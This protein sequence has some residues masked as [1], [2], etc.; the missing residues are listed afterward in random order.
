[1]IK[2][3]Q[4]TEDRKVIQEKSKEKFHSSFKAWIRVVAFIVAAV[5]LPE[6]AAQAVEYDWRVLWSKPAIGLPSGSIIAPNYLQNVQNVNI[7]QAVKRILKDIANKPVT[8]IKISDNLTINLD[9]PLKMSNQRIDELYNWLLGKPCG[10]KAL[11]DF[12]SYK[13]VKVEEQDI[14]V[15]VLSVDIL[16]D[17]IKPEGNPK[18]IKNSLYALSQA[19]IFFGQ[20]LYPVKI[21][22]ALESNTRGLE[23][24]AP[25]IAHLNGDHYVLVT[26]VT[27]DKVYFSDNHRE[28]FLPKDKFLNGFSGYCLVSFLPDGLQALPVSESKKI[29]G[30]TTPSVWNKHASAAEIQYIREKTLNSLKSEV[31][32]LRNKAEAA[33]V[34]DLAIS[35]GVSLAMAGFSSVASSW[36]STGTYAGMPSYAR[37]ALTG[38][39]TGIVV[40]SL[41]TGKW[42]GD[43]WYL[44]AAGGALAGLGANY[45]ASSWND[46]T[47]IIFSYAQ[48]I[49]EYS[50]YVSSPVKGW[51]SSQTYAGMNS[52]V[53]YALTGAAAGVAVNRLKTGD[54]FGDNW[55]FY[56]AGGTAA[57]LAV[58]AWNQY[59]ASSLTSPATA[60]VA[61]LSVK[62]PG[63]FS[64]VGNVF[65]GM[66]NG[67]IAYLSSGALTLTGVNQRE[68]E[69]YASFASGALLGMVGGLGKLTNGLQ[70]HWVQ[71]GI[72]GALTNAAGTYATRLASDL[73][74][75]SNV[76][77]MY[78]GNTAGLAVNTAVN[79]ALYNYNGQ[80]VDTA[81]GKIYATNLNN[82][83]LTEAGILS[84]GSATWDLTKGRLISGLIGSGAAEIITRNPG[85]I[86]LNSKD[87]D[88]LP[89]V[90]AISSGIGG[91]AG[92]YFDKTPVYQSI[93]RGLLSGFL[94]IGAAKVES[95]ILK[96]NPNMT[97]VMAAYLT[98][99]GTAA[100]RGLAESLLSPLT[101]DIQSLNSTKAPSAFIPETG[102]LSSVTDALYRDSLNALSF[103]YSGREQSALGEISYMR[104]LTSTFAPQTQE[105]LRQQMSS[106]SFYGITTGNGSTV[107]LALKDGTITTLILISDSSDAKIF[108]S[109]NV[110]S[111]LKYMDAAGNIW[112]SNGNGTF[113]LY[114]AK[115]S[116][117]SS[118][119]AGWS[120]LAHDIY[121]SGAIRNTEGIIGV[122]SS[123]R[124]VFGLPLSFMTTYRDADSVLQSGR[125]TLYSNTDKLSATRFD[126]LSIED[127]WGNLVFNQTNQIQTVIDKNGPAKALSVIT[128]NYWANGSGYTSWKENLYQDNGE[129]KSNREIEIKENKLF[130][131]NITQSVQPGVAI[132]SSFVNAGLQAPASPLINALDGVF[133]SST[134]RDILGVATLGAAGFSARTYKALGIT[135]DILRSSD[136]D[137]SFARLAKW[138]IR[139]LGSS[140]YGLSIVPGAEGLNYGWTMTGALTN[141]IWHKDPTPQQL[142]EWKEIKNQIRMAAASLSA[143]D[144]Q[145]D[146]QEAYR[147]VVTSDKWKNKL[148]DLGLASVSLDVYASGKPVPGEEIFLQD[149]L[150]IVA[151][152][153]QKIVV[154]ANGGNIEGALVTN[155]ASHKDIMGNFQPLW[156]RWSGQWM[157]DGAY[158][159]NTHI[160]KDTA[161]AMFKSLGLQKEAEQVAAGKLDTAFGFGVAR[162]NQVFEVASGN[163]Y[164]V[165][166]SG[167]RLNA[168]MWQSQG[169][170][171]NAL[172]PRG[173]SIWN[174]ITDPSAIRVEGLSG[175]AVLKKEANNILVSGA[176]VSGEAPGGFAWD[177]ETGRTT[178]KL[179]NGQLLPTSSFTLTSTTKDGKPARGEGYDGVKRLFALAPSDYLVPGAGGSDKTDISSLKPGL[180][181]L[182]W[183]IAKE[184]NL[185]AI[186]PENGKVNMMNGALRPIAND[187]Y[188]NRGDMVGALAQTDRGPMPVKFSYGIK[189]RIS[190]GADGMWRSETKPQKAYISGT[191]GQKVEIT[192]SIARNQN[193]LKAIVYHE[194]PV[195]AML[196]SER[197]TDGIVNLFLGAKGATLITNNGVNVPLSKAE[198]AKYLYNGKPLVLTK[199]ALTFIDAAA[200]AVPEGKSTNAATAVRGQAAIINLES[201]TESGAAIG[202]GFIEFTA[203]GVPWGIAPSGTVG[204]AVLDGTIVTGAT[205]A[206]VTAAGYLFE[207]LQGV[208][209]QHG[210]LDLDPKNWAWPLRG[211]SGSDYS[212]MI[213]L[214][215]KDYQIFS[216][217]GSEKA[218]LLTGEFSARIGQRINY[219]NGSI[220]VEFLGKGNGEFSSVLA[221]NKPHY[222][223]TV[224]S[225]KKSL[226]AGIQ[227]IWAQGAHWGIE[228]SVD[229]SKKQ[230]ILLVNNS[231]MPYIPG[232]SPDAVKGAKGS[233]IRFTRDSYRFY[234]RYFDKQYG[235]M[236]KGVLPFEIGSS[237]SDPRAFRAAPL[238]G[239]SGTTLIASSGMSIGRATIKG[240]QLISHMAPNGPD[241]KGTSAKMRVFY[242][243]QAAKPIV[244]DV[245]D[246]DYFGATFK[247]TSVVRPVGRVVNDSKFEIF[248]EIISQNSKIIGGI[249][250]NDSTGKP[251]KVPVTYVDKVLCFAVD[252]NVVVPSK[253]LPLLSPYMIPENTT[254]SSDSAASNIASRIIAFGLDLET[255]K[256]LDDSQ[257]PVNIQVDTK[258]QI[259]VAPLFG[260]LGTRLVLTG[261]GKVGEQAILNNPAGSRYVS[262]LE[263]IDGRAVQSWEGTSEGVQVQQSARE[264]IVNAPVSSNDNSGSGIILTAR[265]VN[266]PVLAFEPDSNGSAANP[267]GGSWK[268][269]SLKWDGLPAMSLKSSGSKEPLQLSIAKNADKTD[270]PG[271]WE[272][273]LSRDHA[274]DVPL[275]DLKGHLLSLDNSSNETV[276]GKRISS[277]RLFSFGATDPSARLNNKVR[278]DEGSLPVSINPDNMQSRLM[279]QDA[280]TQFTAVQGI[281]LGN[282]E[283][284]SGKYISTIDIKAGGASGR[285]E[286]THTFTGSLPGT[287]VKLASGE[288]QLMSD[289]Q[290]AKMELAS[291]GGPAGGLSI[292]DNV[293][294]SLKIIAGSFGQIG[295]WLTYASGEIANLAGAKNDSAYYLRQSKEFTAEGLAQLGYFDAKAGRYLEKGI[296]AGFATLFTGATAFGSGADYLLGYM[297]GIN[298]LKQWGNEAWTRTNLHAIRSIPGL[299]YSEPTRK[300]IYGYLEENGSIRVDRVGDNSQDWDLI[301]PGTGFKIKASEAGGLGSLKAGIEEGNY[302]INNGY[303]ASGL[304]ELAIAYLGKAGM[305]AIELG[306]LKNAGFSITNSSIQ[307]AAVSDVLANQ[308]S[309]MSSGKA[310]TFGQ[311]ALINFSFINPAVTQS[312]ALTVGIPN[313]VSAGRSVYDNRSK[314]NSVANF[315]ESVWNGFLPRDANFAL[316]AAGLTGPLGKSIAAGEGYALA[317][318]VFSQSALWGQ[319]NAITGASLA[320]LNGDGQRITAS[321]V[322]TSY[323][324][325]AANGA[326]FG[327]IFGASSAIVNLSSASAI[328]NMI[329]EYPLI[330]SIAI[331]AGAFPLA[332][333]IIE[334]ESSDQDFLSRLA[335]NS[336]LLNYARGAVIGLG[337]WYGL[338]TGMITGSGLDRFGYGFAVGATA[339]AGVNLTGDLITGNTKPLRAYIMDAVSG[340]FLGGLTALYIGKQGMEIT[341]NL[342]TFG[343]AG[344]LQETKV[345]GILNLSKAVGPELLYNR[346]LAGAIEWTA[347]SPAF[348][349]GGA[350]WN[351]VFYKAGLLDVHSDSA[352][353]WLMVER[354]LGKDKNGSFKPVYGPLTMTDILQSAV[355]GPRSGLWMKPMIEVFQMKTS[356]AP[357]LTSGGLFEKI[358]NIGR[359]GLEKSGLQKNAADGIVFKAINPTAGALGRA[360]S[361]GKWIDSSVIWMPGF[362]SGVDK[363]VALADSVLANAAGIQLDA[364]P[365]KDLQTGKQGSVNINGKEIPLFSVNGYLSGGE[366]EA[367]KWLP[368]FMAPSLEPSLIDRAGAT[369]LSREDFYAFKGILRENG[370]NFEQAVAKMTGFSSAVKDNFIKFAH[371]NLGEPEGVTRAVLEGQA[372]FIWDKG[373]NF[374]KAFDAVLKGNQEG[375]IGYLN[376]FVAQ[377][378]SYP[379]EGIKTE[380]LADNGPQVQTE[381]NKIK[382][383]SSN[384]GNYVLVRKVVDASI[385]NFRSGTGL[386]DFATSDEAARVS[387]AAIGDTTDIAFRFPGRKDIILKLG[388]DRAIKTKALDSLFESARK[389]GSLI[390]GI[391]LGEIWRD[392][393][394]DNLKKRFET[395]LTANLSAITDK[396]VKREYVSSVMSEVES[397]AYQR[398]QGKEPAITGKYKDYFHARER[399]ISA[400]LEGAD[401]S[402]IHQLQLSELGL[403]KKGLVDAYNAQDK[404]TAFGKIKDFYPD[405]KGS[406]KALEST[407]GLIG[408]YVRAAKITTPITDLDGFVKL[409][410]NAILKELVDNVSAAEY[411]R[412]IK[413]F[414]N[415]S[416]ALE[417]LRALRNILNAGI[418]ADTLNT[419]AG[420]VN[421]L[422]GELSTVCSNKDY[423]RLSA[424]KENTASLIEIAGGLLYGRLEGENTVELKARNRLGRFIDSIQAREGSLFSKALEKIKDSPL[425]NEKITFSV[426]QL[427]EYSSEIGRF[428]SM[429]DMEKA[430]SGFNIGALTLTQ[431]LKVGIK[432]GASLDDVIKLQPIVDSINAYLGK[433]IFQ[434]GSL[435]IAGLRPDAFIAQNIK[436]NKEGRNNESEIYGIVIASALKYMEG[437]F[438]KG[439]SRDTAEGQLRMI[440]GLSKG[441]S[442]QQSSG[443]G[444]TFAF[445]VEMALLAA[446]K[447]EGI[448]GKLVYKNNEVL[449]IKNSDEMGQALSSGVKANEL[450]NAEFLG[451]FGLEIKNGDALDNETDSGKLKD[452][453][454]DAKMITV[455]S[456][457]KFGHLRNRTDD[458]DLMRAIYNHDVVRFDEFH[459]PFSDKTTFISSY[460]AEKLVDKSPA[461][462][463]RAEEVF[464]IIEPLFENGTISRETGIEEARANK[465]ASFYEQNGVTVI[466]RQALDILKDRGIGKEEVGAYLAARDAQSQGNFTV[467]GNK[468]VPSNR[469]EAQAKKVF[470]E[471][472]FLAAIYARVAAQKEKLGYSGKDISLIK[473]NL[474]ISKSSS[475]ATLSEMLRFKKNA[476]IAGASGTME[477]VRSML[478]FN[479]GNRVLTA[480]ESKGLETAEIMPLNAKDINLAVTKGLIVFVKDRDA[481]A[482]IKANL[483][484]KGLTVTEI[485]EGTSAGDILDISKR[486][487]E[488]RLI[489]LSNERGAT[490]IDYKGAFDLI[491]ADAHNWT[492]S[493]LIQA[494]NRNNRSLREDIEEGKRLVYY[495]DGKLSV[496]N[497]D[498][499]TMKKIEEIGA[500]GKFIPQ[501]VGE[502]DGDYYRRKVEY[503][504]KAKEALETS[505]ALVFQVREA[506]MS[507]G[508]I[509]KLKTMV[510]Q[511]NTLGDTGLSSRL[512]E[513][514]K[515]AIEHKESY[516]V[517]ISETGQAPE[518]R[519]RM[520]LEEVALK[521]EDIF[522]KVVNEP[523]A[524]DFLRS[525]ARSVLAEAA[526]ILDKYDSIAY[527]DKASFQDASGLLGVA[528]VAKSPE[529][530]QKSV[531]PDEIRNSNFDSSHPV[532]QIIE[533]ARFNTAD[534]PRGQTGEL[535]L[536]ARQKI[537][538]QLE[539]ARLANGVRGSPD[540][541]INTILP[542]TPQSSPFYQVLEGFRNQ[543]NAIQA[544]NVNYFDYLQNMVEQINAY[545]YPTDENS[546]GYNFIPTFEK[547]S[548][549]RFKLADALV[550]LVDPNYTYDSLAS[551]AGAYRLLTPGAQQAALFY[552]SGKEAL[553]RAY[554]RNPAYFVK[555]LL[556]GSGSQMFYLYNS[557]INRENAFGRRA[558]ADYQKA[559]AAFT[560]EITSLSKIANQN[561]S[562][563]A[564]SKLRGLLEKSPDIFNNTGTDLL[565]FYAIFSSYRLFTQDILAQDKALR[566]YLTELT[567]KRDLSSAE[568]DILSF[569]GA[570]S[571]LSNFTDMF[572]K[573]ATTLADFAGINS[574]YSAELKK[575]LEKN[576]SM[577]KYAKRI[578]SIGEYFPSGDSLAAGGLPDGL[579]E[580]FETFTDNMQDQL[581]YS[582]PA[583]GMLRTYLYDRYYRSYKMMQKAIL[584]VGK[585]EVNVIPVITGEKGALLIDNT[586]STVTISSLFSQGQDYL[587]ADMNSAR[588]IAAYRNLRKVAAQEG[589]AGIFYTPYFRAEMLR[590]QALG[591]IALSGSLIAARDGKTKEIQEAALTGELGAGFIKQYL[592]KITSKLESYLNKLEQESVNKPQDEKEETAVKIAR[593]R[594]VI[595]NIGSAGNLQGVYGALGK[596]LQLIF[597]LDE[598]IEKAS[599]NTYEGDYGLADSTISEYGYNI[600]LNSRLL[601]DEQGGLRPGWRGDLLTV[602]IPHEITHTLLDAIGHIAGLSDLEIG[603][604]ANEEIVDSIVEKNELGSLMPFR[605]FEFGGGGAKT[606]LSSPAGQA[607]L[608]ELRL[609]KAQTL[610]AQ[611]PLEVFVHPALPGWEV[612]V[613][614]RAVFG[615]EAYSRPYGSWNFATQEGA[616]HFAGIKRAELSGEQTDKASSSLVT[617]LQAQ[618]PEGLSSSAPLAQKPVV[619]KASS[620]RQFEDIGGIKGEILRGIHMDYLRDSLSIGIENKG[621][622]IERLAGAG[623]PTSHIGIAN[624]QDA[625]NICFSLSESYDYLLPGGFAD[626]YNAYRHGARELTAG[627]D[628]FDGRVTLIISRAKVEGEGGVLNTEGRLI[629]V[630]NARE[631]GVLSP[632]VIIGIIVNRI[633]ADQVFEITRG[634]GKDRLPV[635]DI[636]GN[637]IK[638]EDVPQIHGTDAYKKWYATRKPVVEKEMAGSKSKKL[639]EVIR[640]AFNIK[641]Q[642]PNEIN[643]GFVG[644][645]KGIIGNI[646]TKFGKAEWGALKARLQKAGK[647]AGPVVSFIESLI[648]QSMKQQPSAS[649]QRPLSPTLKALTEYIEQGGWVAASSPLAQKQ[650]IIA[651]AVK[652]ALAVGGSGGGSIGKGVLGEGNGPGGSQREV[653]LP[654][655]EK[656][657]TALP[658][659]SPVT[660]PNTASSSTPVG[661][662]VGAISSSS[663][664]NPV[665]PAMLPGLNARLKVVSS[666]LSLITSNGKL[667]LAGLAPPAGSLTDS[668]S[669]LVSGFR[670]IRAQIS[671]VVAEAVSNL[672]NV[673]R[674]LAGSRSAISRDGEAGQGAEGA[675]G[676]T[677]NLAQGAGKDVGAAVRTYT[678]AKVIPGPETAKTSGAKSASSSITAKAGI[679]GSATSNPTIS[680][681]PAVGLKT[682]I[683]TFIQITAR[684]KMIELLSSGTKKFGMKDTP[685]NRK[686]FE[687]Y[688]TRK[689]GNKANIKEQTW[690]TAEE[691]VLR[692][693]QKKLEKQ[694]GQATVTDTAALEKSLKNITNGEITG[695]VAALLE[696]QAK[697]ETAKVETLE[698]QIAEAIDAVFARM[699]FEDIES[700]VVK[701]IDALV[702]L[703]IVFELQ[704]DFMQI[705]DPVFD[706]KGKPV[707]ESSNGNIVGPETQE[708]IAALQELKEAIREALREELAPI[709]N[710]VEEVEEIATTAEEKA[711]T[712]E[713]K[714]TTAQETSTTMQKIYETAIEPLVRTTVSKDA[715]CLPYALFT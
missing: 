542:Y 531:L 502:G 65:Q 579:Q 91:V 34:K 141:D 290:W 209:I 147:R 709:M 152:D 372:N 349:F 649:G 45:V 181:T 1:M 700:G 52:Y 378:N 711:T 107:S 220:A 13:G 693:I 667:H 442:V 268:T 102:F 300:S 707:Q 689:N 398:A 4:Q 391:E 224:M 304:Y 27:G 264:R 325:G 629:N 278:L 431:D 295:G 316:V 633:F 452:V 558:A 126:N 112:V 230:G 248:N 67:Q 469:G 136:S 361:F 327:A 436:S 196:D 2:Q 612:T 414:E 30:A 283:V 33:F 523:N 445:P 183:Q 356:K 160:T 708:I 345:L 710:K 157:L 348:T 573:E 485:K 247:I 96:N 477:S 308:I 540:A 644:K 492:S 625:A 615:G 591:L 171:V 228:A 139:P 399:R 239:V 628:N 624:Y 490:G 347:V 608:R 128:G 429:K 428:Y 217:S 617:S 377:R 324:Q 82:P 434:D 536:E 169:G 574:R 222:L 95:E 199:S 676:N 669:K 567:E 341:R 614:Q 277:D 618:K 60:P 666:P 254:G 18:V 423:A 161:A 89:Y 553:L 133:S 340:G 695:K 546:A 48:K 654:L 162:A 232:S 424:A 36:F 632:N 390:K 131:D 699:P 176:K 170:I 587:P 524:P 568:Q 200:L 249:L 520:A 313:A 444:K 586:P 659:S 552:E 319:V 56:A 550:A 235:I 640:E 322:L 108:M 257:V 87:L 684:E 309:Y 122:V 245:M 297:T 271:V 564:A 86:G 155:S 312:V 532:V 77:A 326:I 66:A 266:A 464:G 197:S 461:K 118:F 551:A 43:S 674:S 487:G 17:I 93:S 337:A 482:A 557:V 22:T 284:S 47:S 470:S 359:L 528:E 113:S 510:V 515:E 504:S 534:A 384:H 274:V 488:D 694:E 178:L 194:V 303:A 114:N 134:L 351:G 660:I 430:A 417:A 647:E 401:L 421:N 668:Y 119:I 635:F 132:G 364:R 516:K 562:V 499:R 613:E 507:R 565:G 223:K 150:S 35:V 301:D 214:A 451:Q 104:S 137:S 611:A 687:G 419:E 491:V 512:Q 149:G 192:G 110:R 46:P 241:F 432:E 547:F 173:H 447:A 373:N 418:T 40:N 338:K 581:D 508:I 53:R 273:A 270:I 205:R 31:S 585:A 456:M 468:I 346:A 263:A 54:W 425:A 237:D 100:I 600:N 7:P 381:I 188:Y 306:V 527:N 505:D 714:A 650:V 311:D 519:I 407:W 606:D 163:L 258:D 404:K 561:D 663:I 705:Y 25:F 130:F 692:D 497:L 259:S 483:E 10:S 72:S 189:E 21:D 697:Q 344:A 233:D 380:A 269:I 500:I 604:A 713:E 637:L 85:L 210:Q 256:F 334:S 240:D 143:N 664:V 23:S 39:V 696:A 427:S 560:R 571:S 80:Y 408:E 680:S 686:K 443:G 231:L 158:L 607:M 123:F 238:T 656:K 115:S 109:N 90:S 145:L 97:A 15:F 621:H 234:V 679:S 307:F 514:L 582:A 580:S 484:G 476:S 658:A 120:Q 246:S 583:Q 366:K 24:L 622:L 343:G 672:A 236:Y 704:L 603:N 509:E 406:S 609:S 589:G 498:T 566:D 285:G 9:K 462:I 153:G 402:R 365:L 630:S 433:I 165:I 124:E 195:G 673:L 563:T 549:N 70:D 598:E 81:A 463:S 691:R 449:V 58:N 276:S 616:D 503:S 172:G 315:G 400:Y 125:L 601:L 191:L 101:T 352:K 255:H 41:T 314:I 559:N 570:S 252:N 203:K 42:F 280:G 655:T 244:K 28:E 675:S 121:Q 670:Q 620:N 302:L 537:L 84:Y 272:A 555:G 420:A 103:G 538:G 682:W 639:L 657:E 460:G 597:R 69:L 662:L 521:A 440:V 99:A 437:K 438:G 219:N 426:E 19:A 554:L 335:S 652:A 275:A 175:S 288:Y 513:L 690:I 526:R 226:E 106:T 71:R 26:R 471:E 168:L 569:F 51:F 323:A 678:A 286:L 166:G 182:D 646:D 593:A 331:G 159:D 701:A 367:F 287:A 293:A 501:A 32:S 375:V 202:D 702:N 619:A 156:H 535:S 336:N 459:I 20:K 548:F 50:K 623:M 389:S 320:A 148:I 595:A 68:A 3:K 83:N 577:E 396:A 321:N 360:I 330:S 387:K 310:L 305:T 261:T 37:Y 318:S 681:S 441:G 596:E 422:L 289:G 643:A 265:G 395:T 489:V 453:L 55:Y 260:Q 479:I 706:R 465:K 98:D 38:V 282:Q 339:K 677:G 374:K 651:E 357:A 151:S 467:L 458:P 213:P 496:D 703:I 382:E 685:E 317:R 641:S 14:A 167:D 450:N 127:K 466:S 281:K 576:P 146:F 225:G 355:T 415:L 353:G 648:M 481:R 474:E 211:A 6:Q 394:T 63:F 473:N 388:I 177:M 397:L 144:A 198:D 645:V 164:N 135:P 627:M 253:W 250:P 405:S 448:G 386:L 215:D 243:Q 544:N 403:L 455:F 206:P 457:D 416:A 383:L 688:L 193:G 11:Y 439:F 486:I 385:I 138:Y 642:D 495:E 370:G 111:G 154:R 185:V 379:S 5:F 638:E 478:L 578:K 698:R 517:V 412:Q 180:A 572:F 212:R 525:N 117:Q 88:N 187:R 626:Q 242:P 59:T 251:Q 64:N 533:N 227:G 49:K 588:T 543:A 8:A 575:Q 631:K 665:N 392:G 201:K 208:P 229:P 142:S 472:G 661:S 602:I 363:A 296:D 653:P 75:N 529:G 92:S 61:Q 599:A 186:I 480:H 279:T 267:Q 539:A 409:A 299:F 541:L 435:F 29:L 518:V 671:A 73:G 369:A 410:P 291:I 354:G 594:D 358:I 78:L 494:I 475:Q 204:P 79:G 634:T 350:L 493:D 332:K 683:Y 216:V 179:A 411:R 94:A 76:L 262:T 511:A 116:Q 333:T 584:D 368:F 376:D 328:S 592:H 454:R 292:P 221:E 545:I 190:I 610:A 74:V 174:V 184:Q 530:L 362:V 605:R 446:L 129:L 57:G 16:N 140:D 342:K 715:D 294:A 413:R 12:L 218:Q 712:A 636:E 556:A 329:K 393:L 207:R 506:A 105:L 62:T 522:Q 590:R 371:D 44:Y 298:T